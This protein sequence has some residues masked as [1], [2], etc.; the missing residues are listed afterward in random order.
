MTDP[1]IPAPEPLPLVEKVAMLTPDPRFRSTMAMILASGVLVAG[2]SRMTQPEDI[3]VSEELCAKRG[4]FA[5]VSSFEHG[6]LLIIECKDK[7]RIEVRPIER[8]DN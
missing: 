2:C 5:Y 6:K 3:A 7:T 4:G 1:K 8:K